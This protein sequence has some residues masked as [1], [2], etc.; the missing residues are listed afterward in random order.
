MNKAGPTRKI[1]W[2]EWWAVMDALKEFPK[3]LRII[4]V[5]N[6]AHAISYLTDKDHPHSLR[7]QL[8]DDWVTLALTGDAKTVRC[9]GYFGVRELQDLLEPLGE[10]RGVVPT[11]A[12]LKG[13]E[14]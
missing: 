7:R 10:R 1:F 3:W 5:P 4:E 2:E 12:F 9:W 14:D 11:P 6:N 13:T 8:G